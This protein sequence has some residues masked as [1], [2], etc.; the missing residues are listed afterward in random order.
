M[1][2]NSRH[3]AVRLLES[4]FVAAGI[5]LLVVVIALAAISIAATSAIMT[6]TINACGG[7]VTYWMCVL[8]SLASHIVV[9]GAWYL[10]ERFGTR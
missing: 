7:H 6:L 2:M 5:V 9:V 3:F 1:N 4:F 10:V 8:A